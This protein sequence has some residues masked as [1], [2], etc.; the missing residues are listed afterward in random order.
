MKA[1]P[2]RW[3]PWL[4][5][6]AGLVFTVLVFYPGYLSFDSADQW[7]QA[8]HGVYNSLHPPLQAMLWHYL[9]RFWPGPGGMFTLQVMLYW[10]GLALLVA[11]LKA[12]AALRVGLVLMLGLWPPLF[13]LMPHLWKDVPMAA[14]LVLANALLLHDLRRPALVTR[15]SVLGCLVLIC[16]LRHN[17]LLAVVPLAGWLVWREAA[18]RQWRLSTP[19][20]LLVTVLLSAALQWLAGLPARAP[21]V[22]PADSPWSVVA[23][24][25][26]AAVSLAENQ[27]LFPPGFARD[28]VD[29]VLLRER[30]SPYS[31]TSLYSD[32]AFRH[33]LFVPYSDAER[34]RLR[35][36]WLQLPFAHP[37]AYFAH[38]AR[39]SA[40]LFGLHP[41]VLPDRMVLM[42]GIEPL[43]DNPPISANH[44]T[45]N[46]LVQN[47][48][49]ALIDT[50]LFAGWLYLLLSVALAVVAWRRR[51]QP[52]AR[53]V[54]LLLG[55]TW[56]YS[57]PLTL[58][59]GSAELRYLIWLLQGSTIAV[60]MLYLR[61]A[62]VQSAP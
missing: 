5:A 50:P 24:W 2:A 47:G 38:R 21:S 56:L 31:N 12:S 55:S 62:P 23:L 37:A 6:A 4:A 28:D 25:D 46:R 52:Q 36:A 13:G 8:R 42:P 18:L 1:S 11:Q 44:G 27:L 15:V 59:A 57:L 34:A 16:A 61:P 60:A 32:D 48:L 17:A 40:L 41:D 7:Q 45:L 33:S 26:I 3:A 43:A 9:D 20:K 35:R 51:T 49:N 29:L 30:F 58:I 53:L 54:L 14:L 10:A 39:L 22:T 19:L